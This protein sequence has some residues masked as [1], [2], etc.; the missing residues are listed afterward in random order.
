MASVHDRL[1]SW[2]RHGFFIVRE[3]FD[4]RLVSEL[5]AACDHVLG[6]VRARSRDAGHT[7]TH[8]TSLLVPDYYRDRPDALAQLTALPSAR[9][10]LELIH[11]LGRPLEGQLQLRAA[12]YFHEPSQRDYDG[13]WH[14]DG[15]EVAL[16]QPDDGQSARPGTLL[17]FRV[18]LC[19]DDHLEYVPGSHKRCDTPQEL[20]L[21]RGAVR[22]AP[23]ARGAV[24]IHLRAGDVCVFDTWGIHRGRY[25]SGRRRRTLDLVYGFGP[26]KAASF[27]A[28]AYLRRSAHGVDR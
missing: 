8:I 4:A 12:H 16:G 18:A 27:D 9:E 14:R 17:R 2:E 7:S 24:R 23:L 21:R 22:N 26:R 20:Q 5:A 25:R 13:P 1:D 3:H 15:D 19:A 10:V 11:D 6:Q 28:L